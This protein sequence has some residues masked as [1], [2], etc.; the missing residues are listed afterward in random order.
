MSLIVSAWFICFLSFVGWRVA[1]LVPSYYTNLFCIFDHKS[2]V[3]QRGRLTTH[4]PFGYPFRYSPRD[5]PTPFYLSLS[6]HHSPLA[7][8]QPPPF[9]FFELVVAILFRFSALLLNSR[10]SSS[11][12]THRP[13]SASNPATTPR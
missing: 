10:P 12:T 8:V 1:P 4:P 6:P 7:P 3:G 9:F 13:E 5:S 2:N 11:F